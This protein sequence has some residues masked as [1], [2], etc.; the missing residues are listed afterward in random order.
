MRLARYE[1]EGS[2]RISHVHLRAPLAPTTMRDFVCF[3]AHVEGMVKNEGPDAVV[4]EDWY[5]SVEGI[6]ELSNTIVAGPDPARV[7]TARRRAGAR[8]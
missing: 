8:V 4:S 3:E 1:H 2:T 6:G 7:P 5:Q